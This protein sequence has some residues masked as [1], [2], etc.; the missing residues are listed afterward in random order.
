VLILVEFLEFLHDF[1]IIGNYFGGLLGFWELFCCEMGF[2]SLF[3][4]FFVFFGYIAH[5]A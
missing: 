1:G 3:F 2:V 5:Y 4:L